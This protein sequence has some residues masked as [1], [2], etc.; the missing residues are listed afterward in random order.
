MWFPRK[1]YTGEEERQRN[2]RKIKKK[3][4]EFGG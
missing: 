3:K 2:L 4:W 1:A